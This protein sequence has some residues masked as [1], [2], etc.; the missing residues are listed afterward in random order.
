M[1]MARY[2]FSESRMIY[3]II[4]KKRFVK[5]YFKKIMIFCGRIIISAVKIQSMERIHNEKRNEHL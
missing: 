2:S 5:T 1:E 3:Y 4:K